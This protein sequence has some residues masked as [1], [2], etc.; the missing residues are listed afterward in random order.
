MEDGHVLLLATREYTVRANQDRLHRN[1]ASGWSS[2]SL[3]SVSL[4]RRVSEER[5]KELANHA[6][7]RTL[8]AD[9]HLW[10]AGT[11]ADAFT[12]IAKGLVRVER[13]MASGEVATLAIFGPR[14]SVGETAAVQGVPFPADCIATSPKVEVVQL[15]A[16]VLRAAMERDRH[17]A[18]AVH[19]AV[20]HHT[21]ALRAKIEIM[22]AGS[23]PARLASLFLH[24][25][26]RFGD[27]DEAGVTAIPVVLS[28]SALAHLVSARVETVISVLTT[29]QRSGLLRRTESGFEIAVLDELRA[30]LVK[31]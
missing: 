25:A 20:L 1:A 12:V 4:L 2:A 27:Q 14:E 28:R 11:P 3:L 18:D 7:R 19:A 23:V 21:Q 30:L 26:E 17:V 8:S 24:L 9:E 22:S 6:V 15:A 13:T 16:D 31:G 10:R 29:W 5:V